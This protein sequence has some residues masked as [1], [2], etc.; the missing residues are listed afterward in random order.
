M[1]KQEKINFLDEL[2]AIESDGKCE[3]A[4]ADVIERYLS[5][6][7]IASQRVACDSD[8]DNL[9]ATLGTGTRIL[10][11]TGHLDVVPSGDLANWKTDPFKPT[12]EGDRLFGRGSSDMKSGLAA[13]AIAMIE[14]KEEGF[15]EDGSLRLLATV[16]EETGLY[17]AHQLTEAGYVDDVEALIVGEPTDKNIVFAH[18]G[19]INYTVQAFGKSAHS[20]LPET[21][22]NAIDLLLEFYNA[23]VE[24][25]TVLAQIPNEVLGSFTFCNSILSGGVQANIVPDRASL[26]ANLRTIPEV[27]NEQLIGVL[28]TIVDDL[29]E[30]VSDT[31]GHLELTIDQ[32]NHPVFSDQESRLVRVSFDKV[33][34]IFGITPQVTGVPGA[35]DAAEFIE[36]NKNM[37]I[38]ILGPGNTSV[39]QANEY[40]AVDD[41]LAMVDV[42]KAIARAYFQK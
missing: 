42:Y 7:G 11:F 6:A 30:T 23:M 22:F 33:Q 40:V 20:S 16:G 35:T 29:N 8:R 24:K 38:I 19:I 41:Y 1:E 21:G 39:H 25:F 3:A 13:M 10:G 12:Q 9:V 32:S 2:I 26:T 5:K 4:V 31:P 34:K 17:G 14:L 18:K 15:D 28:Q 37:Q 36:G 27:N